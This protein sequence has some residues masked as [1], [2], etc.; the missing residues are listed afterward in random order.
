MLG[1]A[2]HTAAPLRNLA[3]LTSPY[4]R[5]KYHPKEVTIT[6]PAGSAVVIP[7][8][9]FHGTHPNVDS[10]PRC[11]ARVKQGAKRADMGRARAGEAG[12]GRM[13]A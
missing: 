13:A 5:Y 6:V 1:P 2:S 9:L 7:A 11:G 10:H 4:G 3:A 8:L 12:A